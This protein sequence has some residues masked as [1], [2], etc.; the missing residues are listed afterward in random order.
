M[1]LSESDQKNLDNIVKIIHEQNTLKPEITFGA[2]KNGV[3]KMFLHSTCTN[4]PCENLHDLSRVL[5]CQNHANNVCKYG[6]NCDYSH[7]K[8]SHQNILCENMRYQGICDI[9]DCKYKHTLKTCINFEKGYCRMGNQCSF[10]HVRKEICQDYMYGFCPEGPDCKFSHPKLLMNL[11]P[12][13]FKEMNRNIKVIRC[14]ICNM[15]GH[16]AN[17]CL[18]RKTVEVKSL[19]EKCECWHWPNNPCP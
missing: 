15:L 12:K 11:D 7:Q 8:I 13:F 3:C 16:K 1:Q 17:N 4:S 9:P 18:K 10:A 6:D 14:K 5:S 2:T 19:C